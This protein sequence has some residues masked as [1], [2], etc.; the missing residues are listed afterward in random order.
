[1]TQKVTYHW[2]QITG[3]QKSFND[4]INGGIEPQ[5]SE[6][7]DNVSGFTNTQFYQALQND[8]NSMSDY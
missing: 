7:I 4:M 6:I 1:M 2:I 8:I 5:T 3:L